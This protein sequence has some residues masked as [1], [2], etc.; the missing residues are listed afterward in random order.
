MRLWKYFLMTAV[1]TLLLISFSPHH[2]TL[3]QTDCDDAFTLFFEENYADA[4]TAYTV[5][6]NDDPKDAFNYGFRADAYRYSGDRE[7]ALAD[8]QMAISLEPSE[9]LFYTWRGEAYDYWRE[10]DNALADFTRAIELDNTDAYYHHNRGLA[11]LEMGDYQSAIDDFST[12][13]ELEPDDATAH[14]NRGLAYDYLDRYDLAVADY[15][16]SIELDPSFPDA[17]SARGQLYLDRGFTQ[18]GMD[19]LRASVELPADDY[20][21]LYNRA[22]AFDELKEYENAITDLDEAIRQYPFDPDYFAARGDA[23]WELDEKDKARAD[24]RR[25]EDLTGEL[26]S[27]MHDRMGENSIPSIVLGVIA[28]VVL[29]GIRFGLARLFR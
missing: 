7:L 22:L 4:V 26:E 13:I 29:V 2:H 1:C 8:Y 3:A 14:Y 10:Y 9:A 21:T 23:Y 11:Y 6:I 28:V 20:L 12:T 17:F 27:Y 18:R 24:Y 19:D 5:C 25:Y 16:R 15:S